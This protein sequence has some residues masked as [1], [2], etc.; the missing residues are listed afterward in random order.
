MHREEDYGIFYD[1]DDEDDEDDEAGERDNNESRSSSFFGGEACILDFLP[2]PLLDFP[3][4]PLL[5]F[6]TSSS[7]S[8]SSADTTP[9]SVAMKVTTFTPP[10]IGTPL[11]SFVAF[12]LLLLLFEGTVALKLESRLMRRASERR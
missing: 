1:E 11:P 6:S 12:A 10:P 3:P 5:L 4:P 2:V 7:S 8:S 9:S